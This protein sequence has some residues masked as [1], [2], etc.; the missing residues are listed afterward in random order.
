MKFVLLALIAAAPT[1]P[2]S[3][4]QEMLYDIMSL[5]MSQVDANG[6][7]TPLAITEDE[8]QFQLVEFSRR[9]T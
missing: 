2:T 3:Y 8:L 1:A 6:C 7:P 5:Q 9:E 4:N